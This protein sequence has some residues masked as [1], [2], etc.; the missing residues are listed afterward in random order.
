MKLKSITAVLV[1]LL[2]T[3][4]GQA[5][6]GQERPDYPDERSKLQGIRAEIKDKNFASFIKPEPEFCR[7]FMKDLLVGERVEAIEPIVRAESNKA[8]GLKIWHSCDSAE[9]DDMK[10]DDPRKGYNNM[11]GY[12][13][14]YRYY[15]LELDGNTKNGKEH[16]LYHESVKKGS[17]FGSTGYTWIDLK[18]CVIR[19]GAPVPDI[20]LLKRAPQ[21]LSLLSMVVHYR[22]TYMVL[23]LSPRYMKTKYGYGLDLDNLQKSNDPSLACSWVE[24]EQ[25]EKVE[26][27]K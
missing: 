27:Q 17:G 4:S 13:P 19:G 12:G 5:I 15:Q 14:P 1:G 2:V 10:T 25:D 22:E 8:P 9:A 24:Q 11:A 18:G 23:T 7:A 16:V 26:S 6:A 20:R 3:I 21:T